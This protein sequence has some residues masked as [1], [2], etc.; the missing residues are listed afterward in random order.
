MILFNIFYKKFEQSCFHKK[1]ML[2][3]ND[4]LYSKYYLIFYKNMAFQNFFL[5][6]LNDFTL[7]SIYIF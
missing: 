5:V 3:E 7:K 1:I 2:C 4:D 6:I